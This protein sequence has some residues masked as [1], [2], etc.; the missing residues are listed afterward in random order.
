MSKLMRFFAIAALVAGALAMTPGPAVAQHHGGYGGH[1][2]GWHGGGGGH[3]GGWHGGGY[4]GGW[5][6]GG[7][8]GGWYGGGGWGWGPGIFFWGWGGPY[9]SSYYYDEP[10]CGWVRVRV[11]RNHHR[12]WRR[13]WRCW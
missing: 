7:R 2:G 10:E 12:V 4:R 11:W 6:G 5:H 3:G 1:G 8:H 13:A 9:Y